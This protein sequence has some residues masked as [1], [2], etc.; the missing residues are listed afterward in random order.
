MELVAH[1]NVSQCHHEQY[2]IIETYHRAQQS[3]GFQ[4]IN[5]IGSNGT[6]RLRGDLEALVDQLSIDAQRYIQIGT[7]TDP[8]IFGPKLGIS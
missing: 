1:S 2:R 4:R 6:G 8:R 5:I 7:L 3:P